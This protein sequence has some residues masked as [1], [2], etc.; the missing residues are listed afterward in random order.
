VIRTKLYALAS[1]ILTPRSSRSSRSSRSVLTVQ[2]NQ[3][4]ISLIA[5]RLSRL[6]AN[7]QGLLTWRWASLIL[8]FF[9]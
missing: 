4:I 2:I 5:S 1:V 8:R 7:S 9:C 6:T 3:K